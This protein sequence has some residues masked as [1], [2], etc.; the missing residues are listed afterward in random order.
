MGAV[1]VPA[2]IDIRRAPGYTVSREGGQRG[3]CCSA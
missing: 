1:L 3:C 2:L